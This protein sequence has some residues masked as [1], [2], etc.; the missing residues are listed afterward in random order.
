MLCAVLGCRYIPN[1]RLQYEY[2]DNYDAAIQ[3]NCLQDSNVLEPRMDKNECV[4]GELER[5][6]EC[7]GEFN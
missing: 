3:Q 1:R 2:P 7:G 4:S 5:A 6:Q